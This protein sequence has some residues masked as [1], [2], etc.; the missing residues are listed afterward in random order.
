M[1]GAKSE[2]ETKDPLGEILKAFNEAFKGWTATPEEHKVKLVSIAKAVRNDDDY[3]NLV[4]GNPD[5]NAST[6]VRN[7]IIDAIMRRSNR[8]NKSLYRSFQ[9][10]KE[11]FYG[12]I[13]RLLDNQDFLSL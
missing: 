8:D 10:D 6:A 2:D 4:M 11:S 1:A 9:K 12:V 3:M 7:R 5:I 13:G